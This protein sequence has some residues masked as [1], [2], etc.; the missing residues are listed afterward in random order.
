MGLLIL[1]IENH[2]RL[3]GNIMTVRLI[4]S[5]DRSKSVEENSDVLGLA[6]RARSGGDTLVGIDFSGNPMEG[7]FNNF[8]GLL[9][10]CRDIG[11][12]ITVHTGEVPDVDE[13]ASESQIGGSFIPDFRP[14]IIVQSEIDDILRFRYDEKCKDVS[15]EYSFLFSCFFI[16]ANL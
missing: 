14:N 11:L 13:I 12:F 8:V 1:K 6:V 2:N 7:K 4:I 5:V 9:Q 10:K 16:L 15:N 3:F